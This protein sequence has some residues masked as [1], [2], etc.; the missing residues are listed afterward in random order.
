MKRI[1]LLIM[2]GLIAAPALAQTPAPSP[3]PAPKAVSPALREAQPRLIY[4][5]ELRTQQPSHLSDPCDP[6]RGRMV[7]EPDP[8]RGPIQPDRRPLD[9][10]DLIG[11]ICPAA[12][13]I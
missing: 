11:R 5:R 2:A 12:P 13:R 6:R 4:P 10:R 1:T 8:G 9:P 3:S 7:Q